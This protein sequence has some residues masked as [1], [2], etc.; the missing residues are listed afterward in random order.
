MYQG[1][2]SPVS[3]REDWTLVV[4]A[5]DA[6]TGEPLALAGAAIVLEVRDPRTRAIVLSATSANGKISVVDT[7][8]FQVAFARAEL[9]S[10]SA[11]NYDL[12]CILTLNGET[13]QFI[14]GTVPVLDGVVA[15]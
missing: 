12:G 4:E 7:G 8:V 15:Q 14:I 9:Q 5:D 11:Q 2:L 6:D 1:A 13:K 3:N 10:L